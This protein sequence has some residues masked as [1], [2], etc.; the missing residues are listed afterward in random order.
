MKIKLG[1]AFLSLAALVF[2]GCGG[3]TSHSYQL[4]EVPISLS[5]PLMEGPNTAQYEV[6]INWNAIGPDIKGNVKEAMLTSASLYKADGST[7]DGVTGVVVQLTADDA[8]MEEVAVL[9]PIPE[10]TSKATLNMAE[11]A[12]AEDYFDGDT[13]YIVVDVTMSEELWEDMLFL[14]DFTF[15][16]ITK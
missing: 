16:L 1:I 9:N 11:K 14:G 6:T 4:T 12:D 3:G 7:L 2:A 5:G 8:D 13:F 10:G 15:E